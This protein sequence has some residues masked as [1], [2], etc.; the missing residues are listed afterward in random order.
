MKPKRALISVWDKTGIVEFAQELASLK[1]EILATGKTAKILKEAGIKV[2]EVSD[3]TKSPE[4]LAGRVK[5]LHPKI[6]AGILSYRKESNIE[7]IDIV[8]CNLYPFE[9]YI[10]E[11]KPVDDL[12]ELIDIGGVTL[13]RAAAKNYAFVAAVPLPEFY[14][15]VVKDL[16]ESGEISQSTRELLAL[17][18]FEIV[19]HY[20][21]IINEYFYRHFQK[22]DFPESYNKTYAKSLPLRYGENPHQKAFFY[23]DPFSDVKI[24]KLWGKEL[25]YNN[26]LDID[27]VIGIISEFKDTVCAIIK[28]N[29]PCGVAID[30]NITGAF[31]KAFNADS[32]SAFGGI[33]GFNR[34]IAPETAKAMIEIFFEV[35]VAP[36]VTEEAMQVFRTKKN[37]RIVEFSGTMSN[38]LIRTALGGILIQE[39]D[40]LAEDSSKWQVVSEHKPSPDQMRDLEFAWRVAKYV[41]SNAIVLAKDRKTVG[42][43]AGQMSRVDSVELAIKKS[44][45]N[46]KGSVMASDG[47]FPFRD[48]IDTAHNAGITA[49]VEPG[50]SLRDEEVIK[51]ANEHNLVLLFTGIRHFRH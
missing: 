24:N 3:W 25:S 48:S 16:K 26:L 9:S 51:A 34:E 28:H 37:L 13:L 7:P 30:K 42:I 6:A 38:M 27:S 5:T 41:R 49:I 46:V 50:G 15:I 29:T 2:I 45:G 10:K 40:V 47:F 20:D 44:E 17:K 18:T 35:I 32:K 11:Q 43:G 31:Q 8:I 1:I 36:K 19:A 21:S 23:T 33:V 4:V 22:V 12:V 39:R 14:Q